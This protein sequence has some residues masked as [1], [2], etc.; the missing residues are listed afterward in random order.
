MALQ[1][2]ENHNEANAD[3]K[4]PQHAC[5]EIPRVQITHCFVVVTV[6][7]C[8]SESVPSRTVSRLDT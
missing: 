3:G 6:L 1:F 2:V 4:Y 7:D 5:P 8:V